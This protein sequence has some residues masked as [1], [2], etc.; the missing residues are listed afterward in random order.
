[1]TASENLPDPDTRPLVPA[2][3]V[4]AAAVAAAAVFAVFI[5]RSWNETARLSSH[6]A[7]VHN[8]LG[9]VHSN[10]TH[11]EEAEK[12]FRE[13]LKLDP[14][15]ADASNNLGNIT[16]KQGRLD[17]A[18]ELYRQAST[19]RPKFADAQNNL[20][21][22]LLQKNL[23]DEAITHLQAAV[24]I[25]PSFADAHNNL[26]Y[27]LLQK[28]RLEDALEHFKK[29]LEFNPGIAQAHHN[30]G[31][32][33]FQLGRLTDALAS[34]QKAIELSPDQLI[35]INNLAWLLATLPEDALRDGRRAVLLGESARQLTGGG[36]PVVERTLAAAYAEAGRFNE[37]T[38]TARRA[39]EL[40]LAAGNNDLAAAIRDQMESYADIK[41]YRE[42]APA[43]PAAK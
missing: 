12:Q 30:C 8:N 9:I 33:S 39:R 1:M 22:A 29:C 10:L 18:V 25:K 36:D 20:G 14:T 4:I 37:A 21:L 3:G 26:G 17:E 23:L 42:A 38:A 41:P 32:V 35:S 13:A 19:Q 5:Q 11:M 28:G 15:F 27:A 43:P 24:D 6:Y 31:I 2:W 7:S 16:L 34:Y 40:A